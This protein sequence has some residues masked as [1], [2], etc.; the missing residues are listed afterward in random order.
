V[1]PRPR[2]PPPWH[3]GAAAG[4]T[5]FRT[6]IA[7]HAT[8]TGVPTA[9][10]QVQVTQG[11]KHALFTALAGLTGP[12]DEVLVV[13]PGWPG[14]TEV[15]TAARATAVPVM[16]TA[17][18]GFRVTPQLL[19][20]HRSTRTRVLVLANPGNPTGV[21]HD[22]DEL[23]AIADWCAEQGVQLI[24]DD[25]RR[26]V[27][28]THLQPGPCRRRG[29]RAPI[30]RPDLYD[31]RGVEGPRHD[32]LA[33]RL[34]HHHPRAGHRR[35]PSRRRD[36]HPRARDQPGRSR[37]RAADPE[38]PT[39]ARAIYRA[40]RDRLVNALDFIDGIDCPVPGV[41]MFA[42]PDVSALLLPGQTAADLADDLLH[43]AHVATVPGDVFG[44]P[45][46]LR[47]ASPPS[48]TPPSTTITRLTR[49]LQHTTLRR[50]A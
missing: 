48:P 38:I 42:F 14:L 41:G 13:T 26:G 6:A 49:R 16:T 3:Y 17:A 43:T 25:R 37:R 21:L 7:D 33:G 34:A 23:L 24:A 30:P 31:R 32:R 36:H 19:K 29:G 11:A 40:R 18:T 27:R 47:F 12:G 50:T 35:P 8:A 22:S 39:H 15:V 2:R 45:T 46:H 28:R 1:N 44:A 4:L 5:A 20:Q 9:V 10:E